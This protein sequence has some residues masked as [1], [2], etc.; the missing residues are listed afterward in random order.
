MKDRFPGYFQ[1]EKQTIDQLWK[2]CT[3]IF[4]TSVFLDLYRFSEPAARKTL[5]ILESL[6]DIWIPHQVAF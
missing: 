1:K 3:F 5:K 4:D 6:D 2:E